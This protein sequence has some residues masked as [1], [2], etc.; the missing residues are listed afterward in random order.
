MMRKRVYTILGLLMLQTAVS[1]AESTPGEILEKTAEYRTR[2]EELAPLCEAQVT[3]ART[4]ADRLAALFQGGLVARLRVEEAERVYAEARDRLEDTLLR[5]RECDSVSAEL[6]LAMQLEK[7]RRG[8]E[9]G[10]RDVVIV[11]PGNSGWSISHVSRIADFYEEH[12]SAPLPVSALGQTAL[13]TRLGFAHREAVDVAVHPDT[14]EG[15]LLMEFLRASGVP[16]IA[17]RQAVPGSATGAHIHLGPPSL[18][19]APTA[20]AESGSGS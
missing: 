10:S 20:A 11:F 6:R 4:E 16:F 2:L 3:S 5:I 17:F 14:A 12:F 9:E 7:D 15:K 13:H 8:P 18:R 1:A 19:F